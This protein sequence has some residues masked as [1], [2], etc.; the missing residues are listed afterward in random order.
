M[1]A[2]LGDIGM[3]V[4][5]RAAIAYVAAMVA[6]RA[7]HRAHLALRVD[8]AIDLEAWGTNSMRSTRH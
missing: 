2:Q 1:P 8:R 6:G 7:T 4:F 5:I 3:V